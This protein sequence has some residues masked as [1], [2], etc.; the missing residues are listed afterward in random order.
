[1]Q[2]QGNFP[3]C[4]LLA[5]GASPRLC[6]RDASKKSTEVIRDKSPYKWIAFSL[7]GN[8][9]SALHPV[10]I[11]GHQHRALGWSWEETATGSKWKGERMSLLHR[12]STAGAAQSELH[13]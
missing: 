8:S 1:M 4:T 5:A 2:R 6:S 9:D 7:S 13:P 12:G 3:P 10:G 11:A